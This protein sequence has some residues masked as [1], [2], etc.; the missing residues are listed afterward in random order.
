MPMNPRTLRPSTTFNPRQ[1]SGLALWLDGADSSSLYTTDAGAVEAVSS[2]LDISGCA[3][4][5]DASDASTISDTAGAVDQWDDK[6]GNARH[7]TGTTTSRPTTGTRTQNGR[8]VLDFDGNDF[9][10]G[11]AASLNVLRNVPGGTAFVVGKIDAASGSQVFL[12]ISRNGSNAQ[13][14]LVIDTEPASSS[15]R[16][17][18]RRLDA[19][20]FGAATS[21]AS[22][23][24]NVNVLTGVLDYGNSD[25][26]LYEN[27]TLLNSNT[28]FQTD[29]NTSDTDSDVVHIGATGGGLVSFLDGFIGEMIVYPIAL[30]PADRARVEAYLAAKWGIAGV[31]APATATSDPVGYWRDKSGNNRHATQATAGSRPTISATTQNGRRNLSFSQQ[32]L[33]G[34]FSP[35][36]SSTNYTVAA[37]VQTNTGSFNNQRVFATAAATGNDFSSGRVIPILN[38]G[39]VAGG[40]SA[41]TTTNVSPVSGFST[42]GLFTGVLGSG[43]VQNSINGGRGASAS[44][45]MTS[46]TA[47]FGVGEAGHHDGT[48]RF[49]GAIAELLYYSRAVTPAELRRIERY[50]AAKWG[51]TLAPTVS[52]ADA[53][54]WVNRVYANGGTVSTSTANAVNSFCDAIDAAGIRDRFYRLNLFAGTGLNAAMVPVY[55]GTSLGGT[56]YGNTTDTNVGPFVSGDYAET[57]ASGGLKGNGS[58][59]YLNTGVKSD[60]L[61]VPGVGHL[62]AWARNQTLGRSGWLSSFGASF[63]NQTQLEYNHSDGNT[64]QGWGR[65]QTIITAAGTVRHLMVSRSSSTDQ[66]TYHDAAL[67]ATVTTA[68]T[69]PGNSSDLTVLARNV[70]G[71]I[72]AYSDGRINAYSIGDNMSDA[73]ATALYN[74]LNTFLGSLSRT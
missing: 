67:V 22:W 61:P 1:I 7:F 18:G 41:Y 25:A 42:Y 31:H 36:I 29:G 39:Q 63:T 56:Q 8:N 59:K 46:A 24:T 54:D 21:A 4:W 73:Q 51:I 58:S 6:S 72:G 57:G 66:R 20:G 9:L 65:E 62:S 5:L 52:N 3:L 70:A 30:S 38:N 49:T 53:Q 19:D 10:L 69:M 50:L 17:G 16:A 2:P 15:W 26:F 37:V 60:A 14:R 64:F 74:A 27:G 68:T 32:G 34:S 55:R 23:D 13:A 47:R 33:R 12:A 40:L 35:E 48:A 43:G 71:S 44:G 11:N 45:T 28:S